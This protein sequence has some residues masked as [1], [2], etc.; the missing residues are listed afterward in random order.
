MHKILG[1]NFIQP[2]SENAFSYAST[3]IAPEAEAKAMV[4]GRRAKKA[5]PDE[6]GQG[7]SRGNSFWYAVQGSDK[8]RRSK[9]RLNVSTPIEK[10]RE[11]AAA[12]NSVGDTPLKTAPLDFPL[13]KISD[14]AERHVENMN[15][16]VT[17]NSSSSCSSGSINLT[18]TSMLLMEASALA[19]SVSTVVDNSVA[20]SPTNEVE[21]FN[22]TVDAVDTISH[23]HAS[24]HDL[25]VA[26]TSIHGHKV[27]L[28]ERQTTDDSEPCA[29]LGFLNLKSSVPSE[30]TGDGILF[31]AHS[32]SGST[33]ESSITSW[34]SASEESPGEF[35]RPRVVPS[36]SQSITAGVD[37]K[38][39]VLTVYISDLNTVE[40]INDVQ[41]LVSND[42]QTLVLEVGGIVYDYY[43]NCKIDISSVKAKFSKKKKILTLTAIRNSE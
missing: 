33:V 14:T 23:P 32:N 36:S 5:Q 30:V 6:P 24:P 18:K 4:D 31:N 3:L 19:T 8:L 20:L 40:S 37:N 29:R 41:L 11:F 17:D 27:I 21:V 7:Y 13:K 43:L 38:R 12:F 22:S 39:D 28:E 2:P 15:D 35:N 34:K 42:G 25:A 10:A 16:K 1:A 9:L 26:V